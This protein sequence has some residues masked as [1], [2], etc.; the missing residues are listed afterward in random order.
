MHTVGSING[1]AATPTARDKQR[2]RQPALRSHAPSQ[3]PVML[4]SAQ[5]AR[6][7]TGEDRRRLIAESAYSRAEQ[8]DF[9]PGRELDDWLAAGSGQCLR[10]KCARSA[11]GQCAA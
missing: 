6:A 3:S 8:R 2:D 7:W 5:V 4:V 9:A 1:G 10:D 11:A